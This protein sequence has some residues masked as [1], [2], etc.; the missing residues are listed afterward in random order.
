MPATIPGMTDRKKPIAAFWI[1]A[2]LVA[3]LLGYPLSYGP[4]CWLT[5]RIPETPRRWISAAYSPVRD[6]IVIGPDVL[7]SPYLA[8][9]GLFS[10]K[11]AETF[12][13]I[14]D[15]RQCG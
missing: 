4:W 3:V 1:T 13:I 7:I 6:A 14:R 9:V 2:S 5:G 15:R 12:R 10:P 8:Y 11:L